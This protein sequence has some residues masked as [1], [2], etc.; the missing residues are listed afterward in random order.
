MPRSRAV[1]SE[2][3]EGGTQA[4]IF[5]KAPGLFQC[6]FKVENPCLKRKLLMALAINTGQWKEIITTALQECETNEHL[7]ARNSEEKEFFPATFELICLY[8]IS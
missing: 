1:K 8:C 6:A 4:P 7:V 5:F 3:L 2:T